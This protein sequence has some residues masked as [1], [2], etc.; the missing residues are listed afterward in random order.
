MLCNLTA[1]SPCPHPTLSNRCGEAIFLI[2]EVPGTLIVLH[3][4]LL[5]ARK[6]IYDSK[7]HTLVILCF[8]VRKGFSTKFVPLQTLSAS[9]PDLV[10]QCGTPLQV[11]NLCG[12]CF[13]VRNCSWHPQPCSRQITP[14]LD[15]RSSIP[16]PTDQNS[17]F[18]SFFPDFYS[19]LILS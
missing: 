17:C 4:R 12:V 3:K 6:I 18:A 5:R 11:S 19:S 13:A 15:P 1:R 9:K 10:V 8:N 2:G 16:Q 7:S 14:Q